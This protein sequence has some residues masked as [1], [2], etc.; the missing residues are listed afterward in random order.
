MGV[1]SRKFGLLSMVLLGLN[2]VIGSGVFLLPGPVLQM[3][4]PLSILIYSVDVLIILGV[5]LCFAEMSSH[6]QRSGGPYVYVKEAFGEFA[7]SVVGLMRWMGGVSSLSTMAVGFATAMAALFPHLANTTAKNCIAVALSISLVLINI[8]GTQMVKYVNNIITITKFIPLL[9][10]ISVGI[11][12]IDTSNFTPFI[13]SDVSTHDIIDSAL[14]I[15]YAFSGLESVGVV[16]E[17]MENP[18]RNVPRAIFLTT[19]LAGILYIIIQSIIVGTLGD[20]QGSSA[21]A[22]SALT[23]MGPTGRSFIL[24]GTLISICGINVATS[25]VVPRI[26]MAMA[27]DKIISPW[28]AKKNSQG[29]P[30]I[31]VIL[32]H[33]LTIPLILSGNYTQLAKICVVSNFLQYIPTCLAVLVIRKRIKARNFIESFAWRPLLSSILCCWFLAQTSWEQLKW[34]IGGLMI[35]SFWV[36]LTQIKRHSAQKS[37]VLP[38]F[39]R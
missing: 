32:T 6:Y 20:Y 21:V 22:D 16:V 14:L 31:A 19:F 24:I 23:F 17:D 37:Q 35:V 12:F 5:A 33:C 9:L 1:G 28:V 30:Y 25:F 2:G 38:E 36:A 8:W 4:G 26:G 29:V 7:G 13:Q 11:F 18:E 34:G 39:V 3:T 27:E 15:F 10:F